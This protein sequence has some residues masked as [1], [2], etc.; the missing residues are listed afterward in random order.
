M[1]K[2]REKKPTES[3]GT[4]AFSSAVKYSVLVTAP[5]CHPTRDSGGDSL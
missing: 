1:K 4:L 3:T 2:K 5:V